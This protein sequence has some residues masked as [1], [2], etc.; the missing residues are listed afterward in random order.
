MDEPPLPIVELAS[1]LAQW[2]NLQIP[3]QNFRLHM[4]VAL[5]NTLPTFIKA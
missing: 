4:G 3:Q 2:E 5:L 1:F